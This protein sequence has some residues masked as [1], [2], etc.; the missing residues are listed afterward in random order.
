[1]F[2]RTDSGCMFHAVSY[3]GGRSWS[4]AQPYPLLCPNSK[5]HVIQLT[6]P[7]AVF[8]P[9]PPPP[10]SPPPLPP[11]PPKC[12]IVAEEEGGGSEGGGG[13]GG[14]EGCV[15]EVDD[16]RGYD[17]DVDLPMWPGNAVAS[18]AVTG[19]LAVVFNDHRKGQPETGCRACRTHL[20]LA[21]LHTLNILTSNAWKRLVSTPLT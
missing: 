11:K 5:F 21:G 15:T 4:N 18:G 17:P 14:G 20:H 10:P 7:L 8:L 13:E 19:N 9:P 2:M 6:A 1:M 12:V 16:L 3:T